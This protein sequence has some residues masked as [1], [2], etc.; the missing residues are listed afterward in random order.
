MLS[1]VMKRLSPNKQQL[2]S[3]MVS[4]RKKPNMD[5]AELVELV[6]KVLRELRIIS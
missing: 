3:R 5:L 2:V 1:R 6:T 4:D